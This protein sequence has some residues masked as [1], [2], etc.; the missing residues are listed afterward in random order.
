MK[1]DKNGNSFASRFIAMNKIDYYTCWEDFQV[2][3]KALKIRSDDVIVSITSGGCNIFN[4]L[5]QNPKKVFA[6]DYNPYQNYLLELK[7]EAIRN[8]NYQQFLGFMG[9]RPSNDRKEL[10]TCVRNNLS[11]NAQTFWDTNTDVIQKGVLNV[12]EQNIKNIGRLLRFLKGNPVVEKFLCCSTIEQQADYFYRYING[13]PWRFYQGVSHLNSL[14][15]LVL[16]LRAI[17][18]YPYKRERAEGYLG[19]IQEIHSP[20]N[21]KQKIENTFTRIPIRYNHF[22]SLML[23]GYY[24]NKECY[25]PYLQE[26]NYSKLQQRVDRIEVITSSIGE[27][28]KRFPDGYFTKFNLS[29]IFDWVDDRT[30]KQHLAEICQAGK[31]KGIIFY[32][33]T[34]ADRN[35]PIEIKSLHAD[36]QLATELLEMDR[37]TLYSS[38]QVG[39]ICK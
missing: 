3:Q 9:I 39:M 18:E 16:C 20:K 30:F 35:I 7:I 1:G 29:N 38:F 37:T 33:T 31:N 2:I 36:R 23:I 19:Y 24:F 11:K 13:F 14:T 28:L 5:L 4:F 6:V 21:H 15:K 25:P 27:V 32:S 22:A 8:F 34:R 10:F 26:E 17:R 12:G